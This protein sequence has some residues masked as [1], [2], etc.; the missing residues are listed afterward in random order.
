VS[1]PCRT[2]LARLPHLCLR[3]SAGTGFGGAPFSSWG[4]G[5]WV[6]GRVGGMQGGAG[7]PGSSWGSG[8]PGHGWDSGGTRGVWEGDGGGPSWRGRGPPHRT[9]GVE[10]PAPSLHR[11]SPHA[12]LDAAGCAD[13]SALLWVQCAG[14]PCDSLSL[15]ELLVPVHCW[16]R[17]YFA[18]GCN[19]QATKP[20]SLSDF[21]TFANLPICHSLQPRSLGAGPGLSVAGSYTNVSFTCWF[22]PANGTRARM[23]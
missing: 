6:A 10:A 13:P 19:S 7:R 21:A 14:W 5:P 17:P 12:G 8:G 16:R 1:D 3:F 18:V 2:P 4:V 23:A 15:D 9:D 20:Q 11:E 22:F